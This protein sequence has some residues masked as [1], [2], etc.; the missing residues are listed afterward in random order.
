[1]T[2]ALLPVEPSTEDETVQRLEKCFKVVL[3][4]DFYYCVISK[5]MN[6]IGEKWQLFKK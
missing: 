4:S 3:K 6:K 2:V 1:M 5:L